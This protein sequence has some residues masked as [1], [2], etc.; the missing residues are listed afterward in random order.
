[1]LILSRYNA[2]FRGL[3]IQFLDSIQKRWRQNGEVKFMTCHGSKGREG[4]V[5]LIVN[6]CSGVYGFPSN[7]QDDPVLALVKSVDDDKYLHAEERRLLY[8]AMTRTK[9]QTHILCNIDSKSIFAEELTQKEYKTEVL[10]SFNNDSRQCPKCKKGFVSNKTI[11]EGKDPF[12]RCNRFPV[13]MYIGCGCKCGELV[14]RKI[15]EDGAEIAKCTNEECDIQH[16]ICERCNLGI[17]IERIKKIDSTPF[18]CCH[19]DQCR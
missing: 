13:C 14:V 17:M 8:V 19:I 12:Y 5:V 11:K 4:D 6:L 10:Y 16:I 9:Y 2:Q 7:I 18:Q 3:E 15:G 1:M